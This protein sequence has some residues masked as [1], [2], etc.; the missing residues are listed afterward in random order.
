MLYSVHYAVNYVHNPNV[1]VA[2][3]NRSTC[4]EIGLIEIEAQSEQQLHAK[5]DKIIPR[6]ETE[7]RVRIEVVAILID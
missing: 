6:L 1:I 4:R 5:L 2:T 7:N 3:G